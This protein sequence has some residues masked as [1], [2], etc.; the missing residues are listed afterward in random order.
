MNQGR[1]VQII[2]APPIFAVYAN[3][4]GSHFRSR[5]TCLALDEHGWIDPMD[6]DFHGYHAAPGREER[7]N[8]VG[9]VDVEDYDEAIDG[10]MERWRAE[11]PERAAQA[12]RAREEL[13]AKYAPRPAPYLDLL[14]KTCDDITATAEA[15]GK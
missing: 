13:R 5:I 4:D 2:P 10:M 15:V 12:Q 8:F 11:A 1:I 6:M 9:F 7:S 3:Q 14:K